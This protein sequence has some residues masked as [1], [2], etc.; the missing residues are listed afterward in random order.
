M[1]MWD[2]LQAGLQLL[3]LLTCQLAFVLPRN[4]WFLAGRGKKKTLKKVRAEVVHKKLNTT[5]YCTA[6]LLRFMCIYF[7]L[8]R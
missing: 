3:P 2:E 6:P 8:E 4:I 1:M 7:S 5:W